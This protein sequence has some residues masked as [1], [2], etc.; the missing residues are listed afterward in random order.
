[1]KFVPGQVLEGFSVLSVYTNGN[2]LVSTGA[3]LLHR[4]GFTVDVLPFQSVPQAFLWV[5]SVPFSDKGEPHTLEHL[6]LGKGSKGSI[7]SAMEATL[8]SD[9]SAFTEQT[10]TAYHWC[11]PTGWP[12]FLCLFRAKLDALL[13]PNFSEQEAHREVC[14]MGVTTDEDSGKLQLEEKGTVYNE[15]VSYYDQPSALMLLALH[16]KLFGAN[17][18]WSLASGG[19]PDGIRQ[20]TY[21]EIRKFHSTWY[22]LNRMGMVLSLGSKVDLGG[23]LRDISEALFELGGGTSSG[24]LVEAE[25]LLDWK[26]PPIAPQSNPESLVMTYFP[27]TSA[28]EPGEITFA[29]LAG[30]TRQM[31]YLQTYLLSIFLRC[32]AGGS[33]STLHFLTVEDGPQRVHR[34]GASSIS[35]SDMDNVVGHP[36]FLFFNSV[37]RDMIS[38]EKIQAL[39]DFVIHTIARVCGKV[40]SAEAQDDIKLRT[41]FNT[42]VLAL[43]RSDRKARRSWRETPP[44]FGTR[45][46]ADFVYRHLSGLNYYMQLEPNDNRYR[47]ILNE[48]VLDDIEQFAQKA[49]REDSAGEPSSWLPLVEQWGLLSVPYSAAVAPDTELRKAMDAEKTARMDAFTAKLKAKY[50]LSDDQEALQR[51]SQE[52]AEVTAEI[53]AHNKA[54]E[55]ELLK[56]KGGAPVAA[57]FPDSPPLTYDDELEYEVIAIDPSKQ[58][59]VDKI[60]KPLCTC[61]PAPAGVEAPR[62]EELPGPV[63][64]VSRFEG[65][66]T[67]SVQAAFAVQQDVGAEELVLL[68]TLSDLLDS[69]GVILEDGTPL[70][71]KETEEKISEEIEYVSTY[72]RSSGDGRKVDLVFSVKASTFSEMASHG[73]AWLRRFSQRPYWRLENLP[74]MRQAV[75]SEL[76]DLTDKLKSR[77]EFWVDGPYNA[78]LRQ[79]CA[80]YL[81]AR[82]D[83]TRM[84]SCLR[85]AW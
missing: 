16:R 8:L 64:V 84:H 1:M 10:M 17:H 2:N 18:A 62:V 44:A 28:S 81:A 15:M 76:R 80:H 6:V 65:R 19:T 13:R 48:Q 41:Q 47:D 74:A 37:E 53:E 5:H 40:H 14:H 34:S 45:G 43:T 73:L 32:L 78:L 61:T 77:D 70:K 83:L 66:S 46:T 35:T 12:S 82:C 24:P 85:M 7:V 9:S 50:G 42:Q 56:G 79:T 36:C 30:R 11:V 57:S 67:V 4:T 39:R 60:Y 20:L 33:T 51:Y 3:R 75:R 68:S 31:N 29:W 54:T 21:E 26:L 49:L 72:L 25:P 59:A 22:T 38:E 55:L 58:A 27:H 63:V 52:Y 23:A 69:S 71:L